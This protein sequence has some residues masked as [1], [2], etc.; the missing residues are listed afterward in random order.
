MKAS[1]FR[2]F[3]SIVLF[4]SIVYSCS[5]YSGGDGSAEEPYQIADVNDLLELAGTTDDYGACFVLTANI[6]LAGRT[7]TTAVISPNTVTNTWFYGKKFTGRFDGDNHIISNLNISGTH[8]TGL[9]G[10][11]DTGGQVIDLGLENVSVTGYYYTAGLCGY[12][13]GGALTHCYAT[14]SVTGTS[15]SV[16]GLCGYN[17]NGTLSESYTETTV[18]GIETIGG[19]CGLNYYGTISNCYAIGAVSGTE[20]SLGGLCGRSYGTLDRCHASGSVTG[21][22]N[23]SGIGGLCG[24]ISAGT[25]T[26]CYATGT[27]SGTSDYAG[28]LLGFCSGTAITVSQCYATGSV[29]GDDSIGGLFGTIYGDISDCYA[30]GN[31]SGDDYV[32]GLCGRTNGTIRQCYATGIITGGDDYTGGLCGSNGGSIDQCY[33]EGNVQ[34][35][36][37]LGGLCGY[38]SGDI[39]NS[40]ATGTVNGDDKIGGLCGYNS[41][42]GSISNCYAT[43]LLTGNTMVGG[44]CG[45][46]RGGSGPADMENSFWDTVTTNCDTGYYQDGIY[47]GTVTNV[48]GKITADMQTQATFTDAGWDFLMETANGYEDIWTMDGYPNFVWQYSIGVSGT[49]SLALGE[50][51]QGQI[52]LDVYSKSQTAFNWTLTGYE[53]CT[54]ISSVLPTTGILSDWGETVAVTLDIDATGLDG[55]DYGCTLTI[56]ADNGETLYVTIK[57]SVSNRVNLGEYALLASYWGMSE[58]STGEPCAQAD[59]FVDGTIDS[60]DLR[61]LA[62]SW[63]GLE[64]ETVTPT[65]LDGFETGDFS[66]LDWM[67]YGDMEWTVTSDTAYTGDYSARSGVIEDGQYSILE[68]AI[69]TVDTTF[70]FACKTSSEGDYDYLRFYIDGEEMAA[71]SGETDWTVAMFALSEGTHSLTWEYSKDPECCTGGDDCVWID[72]ISIYDE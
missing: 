23:T 13:Y 63:L 47:P 36:D 11:I 31:V 67:S 26:L 49:R 41:A 54:W 45:Y 34:A 72:A 40:Y 53:S 69:D 55:G 14:G 21:T 59:W 20:D 33:A 17:E 43:G 65:E 71:W 32:G 22:E 30:V 66:A 37:C 61:Q 29:S 68:L 62:M 38:N 18:S 1:V 57:L 2:N 50:N 4:L 64:I 39:N 25:V 7:F 56:A 42:D 15:Y 19:L 70:S 24:W 58:C 12:N 51:E 3:L 10:Y 9:F 27:V 35:D 8:Y 6:D 5:A 28:G 16:G 48:V 46:Q 52:V 60:L 44:F